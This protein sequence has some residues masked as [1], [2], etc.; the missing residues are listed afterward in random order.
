MQTCPPPGKI[1]KEKCGGGGREPLLLS[2]CGSRAILWVG[3][4][5]ESQGSGYYQ[6][7]DAN[8]SP[9]L[10]R[11]QMNGLGNERGGGG[12]MGGLRR[13]MIACEFSWVQCGWVV[14]VT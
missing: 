6:R 2:S 5:Q 14:L 11:C 13:D 4:D 10:S 1:T 9:Q 8:L 12:L 7:Q 3:V